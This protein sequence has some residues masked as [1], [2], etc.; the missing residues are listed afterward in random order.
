[1]D[2]QFFAAAESAIDQ[3]ATHY[4]LAYG[5]PDASDLRQ[6]AWVAVVDA[7]P[8]Y[9]P[10]LG[11]IRGYCYKV[12]EYA[13][14]PHVMRNV[15]IVSAPRRERGNL[16]ALRYTNSYC[17]RIEE[18]HELFARD[19][20]TGKEIDKASWAHEVAQRLAEVFNAIDGAG[21]AES[22][23][24][25]ERKASEVA[26]AFGV[27]VATVYDVTRKARRAVAKDRELFR[28]WRR[29]DRNEN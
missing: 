4:S 16:F 9:K 28:L 6:E 7:E 2:S 24:V 20:D 18:T 3:V 12:A 11:G 15:S 5:L 26:A 8:R 25:A 29:D 17:E 21:I 27:P 22:C 10:E 1:M 14:R 13:V 23:I 19:T